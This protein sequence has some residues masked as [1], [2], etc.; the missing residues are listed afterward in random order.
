MWPPPARKTRP[1]VRRARSIHLA[2][3]SRA[4]SITLIEYGPADRTVAP[5]GPRRL[6]L[7]ASAL[8][9]GRAA[10]V[11]GAAGACAPARP[12]SMRRI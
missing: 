11:A 4:D 9:P 10:R 5:I 12:W 7:G 8:W 2:R 6:A 3:Q 1:Q